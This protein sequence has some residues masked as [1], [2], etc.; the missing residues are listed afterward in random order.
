MLKCNG[1]SSG[2]GLNYACGAILPLGPSV[3]SISHRVAASAHFN[4]KSKDLEAALWNVQ[5]DEK[6]DGCVRHPRRLSI[7]L[8]LPPD[9]PDHERSLA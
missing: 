3:L 8:E 4:R 1:P 5:I 9:H 2:R 6:D 7:S